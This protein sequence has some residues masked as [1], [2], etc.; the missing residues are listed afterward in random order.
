MNFPMSHQWAHQ[1]SWLVAAGSFVPKKRS[2]QKVDLLV[3]GLL[4]YYRED[5]L[6][7][8]AYYYL[9]YSHPW[10]YLDL[11]SGQQNGALLGFQAFLVVIVDLALETLTRHQWDH[12]VS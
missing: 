11:P 3:L 2:G 5:H 6:G 10:D 1:L 4:I 12:L 9:S 7:L 8:M